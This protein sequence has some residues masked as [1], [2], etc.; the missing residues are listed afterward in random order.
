MGAKVG[1][2][3]EGIMKPRW[4]IT[5]EQIADLLE[6]YGLEVRLWE[7]DDGVFVGAIVDG[8][9]KA[10]QSNPNCGNRA[11]SGISW[12]P[13]ISERHKKEE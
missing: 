9:K 13:D 4:H 7:V 10:L 3:K 6:I 12:P 5:N 8:Y 11:E 1:N 2:R